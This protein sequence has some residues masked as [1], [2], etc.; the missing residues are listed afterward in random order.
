MRCAFAAFAVIGLA[1]V[2]PARA[3]DAPA[4]KPAPARPAP[5]SVDDDPVL[6][7]DA[8]RLGVMMDQ[9]TLALKLLAPGPAHGDLSTGAAQRAYALQELVAAVLRYNFLLQR[10]CRTS[11]VARAHCTGPFLPPWLNDAPGTDPGAADLRAM[12]DATSA[13]LIPFWTDLCAKG[14][15]AA[16]DDKLCAIE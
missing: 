5:A 9:S 6:V 14:R 4:P 13:R 10:A 2:A 3:A 8:G 16:H 1:L 11:A 7:I 12:V 15:A